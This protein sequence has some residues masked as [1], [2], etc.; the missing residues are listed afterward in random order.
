MFGLFGDEEVSERQNAEA[1]RKPFQWYGGKGNLV[2]RLLPLVPD[3]GHPYVE[4]Y[5]GGGSVFFA[6]EPA[7]VEVINDLD[8]QVV[9]FFRVLQDKSSFEELRHR[10]S[11]TPYARAEFERALALRESKDPVERAWAFFVRCNQGTSGLAKTV[12]NWSRVFISREGT[13]NNVNKWLMRIAMLDA[14]RWRIMRAQIDNRDAL[15]VIRYWDSDGTVFYLDPPYVSSTRKTI[16]AYD[17]ETNDEHH[18]ALVELLLKCRGAVV[19]SGYEN[20]IYD[21]LVKAGWDIARIVTACYAAGK[22]RNSGLTGA[23]AAMK[24]VPRVEIV[25]RNARA[26]HMAKSGR[27]GRL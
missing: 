10:I 23:G 19:L 20:P 12:G 1:L 26:V 2:S 25:Y 27:H 21:P 3:G 13:A 16:D 11:Y 22:T 5:F 9:N 14:F 17:R 6:R 4:P 8:G 24:K 18:E 15:E 7:P